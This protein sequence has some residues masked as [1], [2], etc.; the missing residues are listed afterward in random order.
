MADAVAKVAGTALLL[1][2]EDFGKTDIAFR[3]V[4]HFRSSLT[5][6]GRRPNPSTTVN[7]FSLPFYVLKPLKGCREIP[8]RVTGIKIAGEIRNGQARFARYAWA[9]PFHDVDVSEERQRV[10]PLQA[11][12]RFAD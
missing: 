3:L 10:Y 5:Y 7:I 9:V 1:V 4:L 12:M 8:P 2:G 11:T 6:V